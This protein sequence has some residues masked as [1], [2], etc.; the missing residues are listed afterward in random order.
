MGRTSY[1]FNPQPPRRTAATAHPV[2]PRKAGQQKFQSSA[3]PKNGCNICSRPG[4][5]ETG[6]FNPQ[7]PRR[8]AAT[9][10]VAT[11]RRLHEVSILSRPEERLQP[12]PTRSARPPR[13]VS[14]LS[15][16]E[17]RLQ[18][19]LGVG[20]RVGFA[21]SILSR[22]EE[23]L[24]RTGTAP[25]CPVSSFNPQPPRRTAATVHP[26]P[27]GAFD[28]VSILSRPEERLQPPVFGQDQNAVR[29]SILS[30]PEERLQ[31]SFCTAGMSFSVFQS[32]AAPKNGCNQEQEKPS[33]NLKFQSSAAPKNGC[34]PAPGGHHVFLPVFQSS[35]AP[36]NGCNPVRVFPKPRPASF[37][38][39]PPRRTAATLC[40]SS[41]PGTMVRFQS[42][43]APKNGCNVP[44]TQEADVVYTVSILS[45]PEERLQP[46]SARPESVGRAGFNPQPPR[47]T[48]AT[49]RRPEAVLHAVPTP[50]CAN[51]SSRVQFSTLLRCN[52]CH[53]ARPGRTIPLARN[54]PALRRH[55]GFALPA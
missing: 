19:A 1:R 46:P 10:V 28:A 52:G 44:V 48:A 5:P 2:I 49:V 47:R 23:R 26:A 8:T 21:V 11:F 18:R 33:L 29:V 31:R 17:E 37:N 32:S 34:N 35:A 22:P 41:W 45:R 4:R 25:S 36:K 53:A 9:G 30:R 7:P 42:S 54:P 6:C 15:R 43:A 51:P 13:C 39:Q 14:I 16:P 12:R 55:D 20:V 24:Q 50:L 38:P 27:V 3:A 40:A